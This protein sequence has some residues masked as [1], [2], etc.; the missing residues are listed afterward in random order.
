MYRL[1]CENIFGSARSNRVRELS[2]KFRLA[3]GKLCLDRVHMQ[4]RG[5]PGRRL[6]CVFTGSLLV[7]ISWSLFYM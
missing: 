1:R 4:R 5:G 6:Y 7:G 3:C 2:V